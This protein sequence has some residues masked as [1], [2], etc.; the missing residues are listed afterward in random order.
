[1]IVAKYMMDANNLHSKCEDQKS[2]HKA[3]DDRSC[4]REQIKR[5]TKFRF[6]VKGERER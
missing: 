3:V 6:K 4:F 2:N 5:K 1:M